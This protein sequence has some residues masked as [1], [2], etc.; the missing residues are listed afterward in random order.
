MANTKGKH[1]KSSGDTSS[2]NESNASNASNASKNVSSQK[3][4]AHEYS[5]NEKTDITEKDHAKNY[6]V[7]HK[8]HQQYDIASKESSS[9]TE[10]KSLLEKPDTQHV[11]TSKETNQTNKN[12]MAQEGMKEKSANF[13]I[14]PDEKNI[15][16]SAHKES[17]HSTLPLNSS[18]GTSTTSTY[19]APAA[20]TASAASPPPG[21][22]GNSEGQINQQETTNT[23]INNS[24]NNNVNGN[25]NSNVN[26]S[27]NNNINS[28]INNNVNSN[29]N[30]EVE[31]PLSSSSPSASLPSSSPSSSL[32]DTSTPITSAVPTEP[33]IPAIPAEPA[34]PLPTLVT[35][36][37]ND[38]T[39]YQDTAIALNLSA[40]LSDFIST[41]NV[42]EITISN[43]PNGVTLSAG[44]DNGD[45]SWTI[46][47]TDLIGLTLTPS[48]DTDFD[49]TLSAT[50]A[51][52]TNDG[53]S[54]SLHGSLHLNIEPPLINLS[55]DAFS[56]PTISPSLNTLIFPEINGFEDTSIPLNVDAAL[57]TLSHSENLLS[58]TINGIP[59]DASLSTGI[60]NHNGSWTISPTDISGLAITSTTSG[61]MD[62]TVSA[63]TL[64]INNQP[65]DLNGTLHVH[66][67]TTLTD[68]AVIDNPIENTNL[69]NLTSIQPNTVEDL[70]TAADTNT[71][72]NLSTN[73]LDNTQIDTSSI[74]EI[75]PT[76]TS[77][78]K[79]GWVSTIDNA[80]AP[81]ASTDT[82]S[83]ASPPPTAPL[84]APTSPTTPTEPSGTASLPSNTDDPFKI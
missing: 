54:L 74:E 29:I 24:V 59:N 34:I 68:T 8:G 4:D 14:N 43:L 55:D 78:E 20:P 76:N 33:T 53:E 46:A 56:S 1:P 42:S 18:G 49:L 67:E 47:A 6:G 28:S 19:T 39:G 22:R 27:V 16:A 3:L 7:L 11:A 73:P 13:T 36:P 83:T 10:N 58:V 69:T 12:N 31:K 44:T 52:T 30:S 62:L 23:T 26:N 66:V 9:A 70:L 2:A 60:D 79:E 25:I 61:N 50:T 82:S 71:H 64:N 35:L 84:A 21:N 38:I 48:T 77:S 32:I 41:G 51:V 81:T 57:G 80:A 40:A 15:A 72:S 37:L 65:I 75:S 63:T 5:S 45:G 17:Q